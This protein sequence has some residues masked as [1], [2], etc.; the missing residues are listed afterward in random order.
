MHRKTY[1]KTYREKHR[2]GGMRKVKDMMV[3][4][5]DTENVL[6]SERTLG[7]KRYRYR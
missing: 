4:K 5:W 1:R 6:D 2:E 7:E 3:G